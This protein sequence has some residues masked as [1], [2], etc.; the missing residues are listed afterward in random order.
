MYI[1]LPPSLSLPPLSPR[2]WQQLSE[3]LGM[4]IQPKAT[5]TFSKCLEMGLASHVDTI[6]KVAEVAGKEFSIE[7]VRRGHTR[8]FST[9]GF[10][11]TMLG[12][13]AQTRQIQHDMYT[14][15]CHIKYMYIHVHSV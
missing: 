1:S 6:A 9:D 14:Y 5:L 8:H 10:L 12:P 11:S 13:V 3:E 4:N 7:Q 2:H 15:H